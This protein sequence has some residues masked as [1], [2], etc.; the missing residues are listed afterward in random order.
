MSA[1]LADRIHV[2]RRFTR[3]VRVD[4]DWGDARSLDGYVCAASA[5]EALLQM[6]RHRE[7]TGHGAFT[8]TGP[9]GSGKSSLAVA[10]ATLAAGDEARARQLLKDVRA[11][12]R[13][14][15]E[16][17]FRA[18]GKPWSIAP[19]VGRREDPATVITTALNAVVDKNKT[20]ARKRA[21]TLHDWAVRIATDR[22]HGGLLL[23][24]D[25]MGKFLEAA[26]RDTGDVYLFQEL[27]EAASRSHGRLV[28]VG[29]LHQAFD[30]Y[31]HRL[32]REARDEWLKVQG[33]FLDIPINLAG[34]EQLEL[35][36]RAIEG[37]KPPAGPA[38]RAVAGALQGARFGEPDA[39]VRRLSACW[40]LH[41]MVAALLGPISR[42]R[43]GQ[44]Q[45]SLFGF[46]N[47]A[48]PFGFQAFLHEAPNEDGA[49]FPVGRLWDYLHANLEPAILASPDGHRWSTALEAVE[50]AEAKG[51]GPDH[52]AVLKAIALVDLFKDRS[53]LQATP[54]ALRT[55]TADRVAIDP[56]LDDLKRWSVVIWRAH[57]GAY[58]IYAGSDFDIEAAV[59]E[60][61]RGG[62]SVD[63][64]RL[65]Q[66]AALQPILAK[67]H[68]EATG[69]LRWF[70]VEL[71]PLHE[72]EDRIRGYKPAPGA[73]GLFLLVVSA[74][75]ETKAEA[76]RLLS[77]AVEAAHDR[78]VVCGWTRESY[79]IREM[80]ADLAALEH[81][82]SNRA[83]L[84]GDAIARREV[85]ARL[86]RIAADLEDRL[87]DAI[88]RVDWY[89]PP[90]AKGEIDAKVTGP[91]GLSVLASRLADWR[92]P[93]AP[94]LPNELLNRT[95]PSS[96]AQA[97]VRA[98]LHAMVDHGDR[99]RLG[100]E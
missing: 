74:N 49:S 85:D 64:K 81:V 19:V 36:G 28:V 90:A 30:E 68:Y 76:K 77:Q 45:R 53:G 96:N 42:R 40:P 39:L 95:R 41:P 25:E 54:E 11:E 84:E 35:I 31:A 61:R 99:P 48:E 18:G 94:R 12:D 82:R 9:Y 21:E 92:Y 71:A 22:R 72:V 26:A 87:A 97:A 66:R 98:L 10:L 50:R 37:R 75:A 60:A 58:A 1:H 29:I 20:L 70:E 7:A 46:L 62:V 17:G 3:A 78:L 65:A 52:L 67:R 89:L 59:D 6:S 83:E 43:F 2:A 23:I 100:I 38:V 13:A 69:A 16:R 34:E 73:A 55:V 88:D 91:A 79:M 44:N 4:A 56:L 15:L 14:E 8:W 51:A 47:S 93:K 86:A 27:A 5:V 33:R 80:A 63:Y 24:V 32:A 57:L